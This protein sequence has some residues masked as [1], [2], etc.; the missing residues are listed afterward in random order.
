MKHIDRIGHLH[1]FSVLSSYLAQIDLFRHLLILFSLD[2]I[3]RGGASCAPRIDVC[4]QPTASC[5][6]PRFDRKPTKQLELNNSIWSLGYA[7]AAIQGAKIPARVFTRRNLERTGKCKHNISKTSNA[8]YAI[9]I[10]QQQELKI[11][12]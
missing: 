12:A 1:S 2:C 8:S 9:A 10:T 7:Q 4:T 6:E 11:S 3:P 5:K